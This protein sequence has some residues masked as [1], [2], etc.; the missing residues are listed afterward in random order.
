MANQSNEVIGVYAAFS[1]GKWQNPDG[2]QDYSLTVMQRP[3]GDG[4]P[5]GGYKEDASA[6]G[7][8]I[9]LHIDEVRFEGEKVDPEEG[10]S[11]YDEDDGGPYEVTSPEDGVIEVTEAE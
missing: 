8:E 4:D 10:Q 6:L 5:Y 7:R 3:G 11:Y 2:P 1:V 9:P